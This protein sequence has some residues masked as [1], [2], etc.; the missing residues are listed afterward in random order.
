MH[1]VFA[2]RLGVTIVNHLHDPVEKIMSTTQLI[3]PFRRALVGDK[4]EEWDEMV[5]RITHVILNNEIDCFV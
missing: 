1:S 5:A 3:I 2:L 4:L